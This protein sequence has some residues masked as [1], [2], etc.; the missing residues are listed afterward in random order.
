MSGFLGE[1][2]L[3]EP[4]EKGEVLNLRVCTASVEAKVL[5]IRERIDSESGEMLEQ[6]PEEIEAGDAA[7]I[8][9]ETEPVVVERFSEIPP[10]GRFALVRNGRNIGAGVVLEIFGEEARKSNI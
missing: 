10:L 8:L 5:E 2:V 3:L 6:F 4:L 9:F 1:A 7:V